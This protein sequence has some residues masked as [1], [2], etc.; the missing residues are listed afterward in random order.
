[1]HKMGQKTSEKQGKH[2]C[3]A[4]NDSP[5]KVLDPHPIARLHLCGGLQL[6]DENAYN[7][8]GAPPQLLRNASWGNYECWFKKWKSL[9]SAFPHH[10]AC[11]LISGRFSCLSYTGDGPKTKSSHDTRQLLDG[12]LEVWK[13]ITPT[14]PGPG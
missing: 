9:L 2:A 4:P 11:T 1:V 6:L 8:C 14:W 7:L 5:S 3:G 13:F 12:W 10:R